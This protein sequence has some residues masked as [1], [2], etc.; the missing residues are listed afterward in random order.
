[1]SERTV[2]RGHWTLIRDPHNGRRW[3]LNGTTLQLEHDP[4][5]HGCCNGGGR[6]NGAWS[7]YSP[8]RYL[9]LVDGY[10]TGSMEYVEESVS[11][12]FTVECLR[13]GRTLVDDD[14]LGWYYQV[15][16]TD[17]EMPG[18]TFMDRVHECDGQPHE[19][20]EGVTETAERLREAAHERSADKY[21][22]FLASRSAS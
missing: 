1:M 22:E 14:E 2:R 8:S 7:L 15:P 18:L 12:Y 16:V 10:L 9:A 21:R 6:C 4:T 5:S 20:G 17:A 19:L 11:D 13:C 3:Q